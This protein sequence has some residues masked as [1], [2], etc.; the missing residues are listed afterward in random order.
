MRNLEKLLKPRSIALI[1]ASRNF[2]KLNGR[3][4][5]FLLDKG[6]DGRILPVNPGYK[7]IGDLACYPDIESIAERIDLAIIAVSA[8]KVAQSLREVAAK[9]VPAAI[10]FSSGF[11]ETGRD[12]AAMER[13][14]SEIARE[15]DVVLCG[16]NT[17]GLINSFERVMATFSQFANGETPTGPVGFVTQ[18]GA[19]GTAIAAL[20]RQRGLG[21]G[22]FVNT[23]NEAGVGFA[24][25][26]HGV[27]ADQR[28]GLGAGYIE[29]LRDGVGFIDLATQAL[30][31][32][33]PLVVTKVGRTGAGARAAASHTGS[34]AGEDAVFDGI[35][36]QYDVVR[37]PDEEYMLDVVEGFVAGARPAGPRVGLITQSGGAGVLMADRAQE[38]GLEVA[39]LSAETTDRLRRIVPKFG[40]VANPVD[41]T[42]QFIAEPEIFRDSVKT[43][44]SDPGVDFGIVW[45]QL[46][47]EFVDT[48]TQVFEDIRRGVRKPVLV[49]WVAGPTNGIAALREMG[50]PL[51]RSAGA[52]LAAARELVTYTSRRNAWLAERKRD[53]DSRT[54]SVELP[55]GGVVSS[56]RARDA[57][58]RSGVTLV[59]TELGTSPNEVVHAAQRIGFPVALKIESPQITHK[60]DVGGVRLGI[61]DE[62]E[63]EQAYHEI[64]Q[65]VSQRCPN[66]ALTGVLVQAMETDDAV[67]LAI[68]LK[69]DSVFGMVVMLGMGGVA[70]E[71]S[72]DVVFRRAPV[73]QMQAL[74]MLEALRGAA[75]LGPVR[76]RAAI[77]RWAVAKLVSAVSHFGAANVDAVSEL[78][79]NPVRA[80]V[81]GAHAVDWLLITRGD[82][83]NVTA[84]VSS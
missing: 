33:K 84:E 2:N 7:S 50:F 16:P 60:S 5:K 20:A 59:D 64:L 43:V 13:E 12:G 65:S 11:S 30:L 32:D 44:L 74:A 3:P 77:D 14:L 6:Y 66:A 72:P 56:L 17:L 78:D 81:S 18:S 80:Q 76:G 68:G 82:N 46:M 63:A 10:V 24:E 71:V 25:V 9:G 1:G 55:L 67:E 62:H 51:F 26:M 34:L 35:C 47:H 49:C 69:H 42:A 22:Y 53:A 28:I 4:L 41:I 37:A 57:L 83:A 31:Q 70:L 36:A 52:A 38:L 54:A 27:L 61:R 45:F 58:T 39:A 29:G 15:G 21:L 75:L 8:G 48:I 73:T 79:M 23:G 19:F 40:A